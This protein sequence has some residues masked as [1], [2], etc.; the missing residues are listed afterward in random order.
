MVVSFA[1][2]VGPEVPS[3]WRQVTHALGW[4][5]SRGARNGD[6][7]PSALGSCQHAD[8][9]ARQ[10]ARCARSFRSQLA[11]WHCLPGHLDPLVGGVDVDEQFAGPAEVFTLPYREPGGCSDAPQDAQVAAE[12][13][14]GPRRWLRLRAAGP[15]RRGRRGDPRCPS[16]RLRAGRR[17]SVGSGRRMGDAFLPGSGYS[18]GDVTPASPTL[19]SRCRPRIPAREQRRRRAG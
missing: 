7:S 18:A 6:S 5:G 10:A 11:Y 14:G 2:L 3:G 12:G 4:G 8:Q 1:N 17:S 9:V 15:A 16:L 19:P 13:C